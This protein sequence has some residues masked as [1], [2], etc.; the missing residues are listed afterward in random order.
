MFFL[1]K[2]F[3]K[4]TTVELYEIIKS[5]QQIFL[6]EQNIVYQ[7]L[8]DVDKTSLHCFFMDDGRVTGYLRAFKVDENTVR[9]GRVLTL[10][11]KKG[12]GT[13]LMNKSCEKIKS[14]FGCNKVTLHSQKQAQGFYEKLGFKI[15]SDE[16][17]EQGIIHVN[18]EK[19]I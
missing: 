8:D 1:A 10:E 19:Q 15:V 11:H 3:E 7:D 2:T 17:L 9:I 5:R 12:V 18:M 6:L 14:Y 16:Y 13:E 4:L